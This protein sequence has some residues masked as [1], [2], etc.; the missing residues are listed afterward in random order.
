MSDRSQGLYEKFHVRRTDGGS[1]PGSKHHGCDYFVLD[2]THDKYGR[3]ALAA[4]ADAC[5]HE[6]P[7][8]AADLRTKLADMDAAS[9]TAAAASWLV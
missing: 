8:L 9:R 2:F 5:E 6:Y 1:E 4:Y 3:V 7:R